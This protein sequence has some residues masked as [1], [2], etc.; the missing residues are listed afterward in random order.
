[1]KRQLL[2]I[3][4]GLAA[5]L[6]VLAVG[7]AAGSVIAAATVERGQPDE[8]AQSV[9]PAQ[10][11]A[12]EGVLIASVEPDGPAAQAGVRRG[13]ILVEVDGEAVDDPLD[14][15]RAL[16]D[17]RPGDQIELTVWH[18]DE[19]RVLTATLDERD[20]RGWLGLVPCGAPHALTLARLENLRPGALITS[21]EPASPAERA[22]LR[23]GDRIVALDG[24]MLDAHNNLAALI[25]ARKPGDTITLEVAHPGE[26]AREVTVELGEH[27]EQEGKAYLGVTYQPFLSF[28]FF[29]EKRPPLDWPP[30]ELEPVPALP[31]GEDLQGAVVQRVAEQSPAAEAGLR[32]GDVITAIDGTPVD[33]PRALEQVVSA[34]EPGDTLTLTLRRP[35]EE[36][37]RELEVTL[38]EHPEKAGVA[39]L[40][41][42]AGYVIRIHRW[43]G[44]EARPSLVPPDDRLDLAPLPHQ[45]EFRLPHDGVPQAEPA[46]VGTSA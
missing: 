46:G 32:R 39:Y 35:G 40:G 42:Q 12:E 20:G 37:A 8:T 7:L 45:F 25:A 18:G 10:A 14:L 5:L 44:D 3:V 26:E 27:P 28:R 38:G 17:R 2:R 22:G 36:E 21:V 34:R 23:E 29:G 4:V 11:G 30:A 43:D 19:K 31:V 1:M 24:Q 15:A 16:E 33:N 9:P 41:V 13:D 6:L